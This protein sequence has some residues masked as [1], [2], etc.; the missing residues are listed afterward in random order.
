MQQLLLARLR[1]RRVTGPLAITDI[2]RELL[3]SPNSGFTEDLRNPGRDFT[4]TVPAR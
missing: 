2:Q 1:E 4:G 3:I